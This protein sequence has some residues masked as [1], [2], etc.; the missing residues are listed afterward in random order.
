MLQ[1]HSTSHALLR[2]YFGPGAL[3][4][5]ALLLVG[6]AAWADAKEKKTEPAVRLLKSIPVPVSA[7]NTTAGTYSYDI[8]YVDQATGVYYLADRS[9]FAV[10]PLF[11]KSIVT[12]IFPNNGHAPFA[13]FKPCAIQ[14][15]GAN[16]CAGPNGVVAAFPWLFVT[17]APSRLLPF[18]LRTDRPTTVSEVAL[19]AAKPTPPTELPYDPTHRPTLPT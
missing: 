13:G 17:D 7:F 9:N 15:A 4:I 6:N 16:D 2:K 10:D 5:A 1:R 12:Q 3:A 19:L 8:S 11:P 14:P 18:H